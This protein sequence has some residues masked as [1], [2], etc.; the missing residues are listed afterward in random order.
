MQEELL[1]VSPIDIA[2]QKPAIV[3]IG[4]S[5]GGLNAAEEFFKAFKSSLNVC[6]VVVQHLSAKYKSFMPEILGKYTS[7]D[8]RLARN[9]ETIKGGQLYLGAC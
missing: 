3:G 6:F 1:E 5:A 9:G 8:V 4:A 7:M 2:K